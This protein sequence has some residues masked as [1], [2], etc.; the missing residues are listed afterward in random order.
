[1]KLLFGMKIES[2]ERVTEIQR[3]E[4]FRSLV[5]LSV[6]RSDYHRI[7]LTN[8]QQLL[9]TSIQRSENKQSILQNAGFDSYMRFALPVRA[10]LSRP[11]NRMGQKRDEILQR[12]KQ[13]LTVKIKVY[14]KTYH[15]IYF[16]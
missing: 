1:M 5:V 11:A 14:C 13:G 12:I 4:Q 8:L 10:Q 16:S 15:K 7:L 6:Q 9:A 3:V 2:C